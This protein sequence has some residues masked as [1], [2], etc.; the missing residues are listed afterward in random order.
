MGKKVKYLFNISKRYKLIICF[1]IP[2]APNGA[3]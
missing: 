2:Q 1:R 3:H